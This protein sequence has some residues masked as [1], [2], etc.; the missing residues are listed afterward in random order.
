MVCLLPVNLFDSEFLKK[1]F[2]KVMV[3]HSS[4]FFVISV[5]VDN[6]VCNTYATCMLLLNSCN[7]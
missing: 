3:D 2:D 5:L 6:H 7:S 1:R 4:L